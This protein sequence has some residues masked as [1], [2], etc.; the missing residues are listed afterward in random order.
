MPCECSACQTIALSVL[1]GAVVFD[2]P[3][4][5][6]EIK[7]AQGIVYQTLPGKWSHPLCQ[8]VTPTLS[9]GHTHSVKWSHPLCQVVT[10]TLSSGHTHSVKWSHPLCQVVTPTLSSGHT[11][12]VKWSHPVPLKF[13]CELIA[14]VGCRH[15]HYP[16]HQ[17]A[18]T[19]RLR[20]H[21]PISKS[22]LLRWIPQSV[23]HSDHHWI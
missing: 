6:R 10:P 15:T 21:P 3:S 9:S 7:S 22:P 5:Q 13:L 11:H 18:D 16:T 17:L 23:A 12:S 4:G 20:T 2:S 1:Q 14:Y 8:V 19:H